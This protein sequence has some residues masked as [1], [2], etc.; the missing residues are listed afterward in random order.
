[1]VG[2]LAQIQVF[3]LGT[4]VDFFGSGNGREGDE[5]VG[6]KGLILV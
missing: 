5:L 3:W 4:V 6:Q 1:M 2:V